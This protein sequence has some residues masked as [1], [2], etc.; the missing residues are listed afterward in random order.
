V[1]TVEGEEELAWELWPGVRGW[2][3]LPPEG[4]RAAFSAEQP[5][6]FVGDRVSGRYDRHA[7][8]N[9]GEGSSAESCE[10][11]NVMRVTR[12][13]NACRGSYGSYRP[14]SLGDT[15]NSPKCCNKEV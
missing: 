4:G 6:V 2:R 10:A 8:L 9:G 1:E 5:E 15:R 11:L 12:P 14:G 3:R 7:Y 13:R